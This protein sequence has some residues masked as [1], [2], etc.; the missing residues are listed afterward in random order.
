MKLLICLAIGLVG[1]VFAVA[2]SDDRRPGTT[3]PAPGRRLPPPALT[4]PLTLEEAILSRRSVREFAEQPLTDRE[5]SQL[6]W[7]A[8]GVTDERSGHRAAP[9]AG[10]LFP[11]E[12]Y[13]VTPE[14]VEHY[15][16]EGHRLLRHLDGDQRRL[17]QAAAL[18]QDAVGQAPLCVVIAAVVER[19]AR[20]YGP[21]SE[22]YCLI[23]AGHVAQNILLQATALK[24][25]AVPIGAFDESS[26][27]RAL[28][29]PKGHTVLYLIPVGRPR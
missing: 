26:V 14:A 8:Q 12:L 2:R 13:L 28:R 25:G 9:S 15:Q 7:A 5:L 10:A 24:L 19:T 29:L 6:C 3:Q 16:S 17:L 4:G 11:I 22:R 1:V 18:Q 21:Q 20:K 27:S 23:E